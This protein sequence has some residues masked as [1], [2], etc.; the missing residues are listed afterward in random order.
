MSFR[1]GPIIGGFV[2]T[3]AG[4]RWIEGVMA[5]ATGILLI[6]YIVTVPETYGPKILQNRA[7]KL[8]EST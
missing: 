6:L 1:L 8:S 4:W 3:G 2:A 5:I 7:Q